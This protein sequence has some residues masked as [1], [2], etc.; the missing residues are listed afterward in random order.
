M[1]NQQLQLTGS[2]LD[3][4]GQL[5]SSIGNTEQLVETTIANQKLILIGEGIQALGNALQAIGETNKLDRIGDWIEAAG[6]A[7]SGIAVSQQL[8]AG[9]EDFESIRLEILGDMLQVLGPAI[10]AVN[11]DD[12]TLLIA[13]RLQIIGPGLEAIGGVYELSGLE[14]KGRFLTFI[15]SW[16]Q[17][18]GAFLQ[19]IVLTYQEEN[20]E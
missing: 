14:Q 16:I 5:L 8:E 6:A 15:G 3:A 12:D 10:S 9:E 7:T 19:A 1:E 11:K 4:I 20:R 18:S 2:W 17:T 13:I